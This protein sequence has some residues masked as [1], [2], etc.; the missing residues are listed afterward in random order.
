[1][2]YPLVAELAEDGIP[3]TVS[4]QVLKLASQPYYRSAKRPDP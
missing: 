4:C 2:T 1:M 3:P